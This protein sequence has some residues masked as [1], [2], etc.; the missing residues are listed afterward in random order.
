[1]SKRGAAAR[2]DH[3]GPVWLEAMPVRNRMTP[4]PVV[5][6]VDSPVAAAADTMRARKIR[7]L[8][9]VDGD[10]RLVGIVTDRDLRQ[11]VFDPA[12][13]ERLGPAAHALA[14]LPVREVMTWGVVA[15]HP[16]SD[17]RDAAQLMHQRKIGAVPVVERGRVV[18]I[19]TESDVL[20][21]LIDV[22]RERLVGVRPLA[23]QPGVG[24]PYDYGFAWEDSSA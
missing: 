8:P 1:M 5:V 7:H 13:H 17:V 11:A 23:D 18:G 10:G 16:D 4:A 14:Q 3:G 24:Q 20:A 21:A 9:V 22:L 6:R 2:V 15:V 12:I 19:L